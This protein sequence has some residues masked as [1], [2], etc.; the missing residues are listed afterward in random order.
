MMAVVRRLQSG[1]KGDRAQRGFTDQGISNILLGCAKL[2]LQDGEAVQLLAAASGVAGGRMKEQA[3]ANSVWALGKLLGG[4]GDTVFQAA[5]PAVAGRKCSTA[6]AISISR[7][8][9]EIQRR[10]GKV[11]QEQQE[12]HSPFR[13]KRPA[14]IA[15]PVFTSQELS[16]MLYCMALLQP[17]IS[18]AVKS[19]LAGENAT[20]CLTAA[21]QAL[22]EECIRQSF[23]GFK[24]QNLANA[25]WAL[26]KM[27]HADQGLFA[28]AVAAAQRP[29]FAAAALP[30]T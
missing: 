24:P 22:A 20:L 1:G 2:G 25:T 9:Q 23:Q 26:A 11:Q 3:I 15:A 21:A 13:P 16:N 29:G 4:G 17:Y 5:S 18:A 27:S 7:L 12:H 6:T 14:F 19:G 10:F 30:M 8:L 28:A